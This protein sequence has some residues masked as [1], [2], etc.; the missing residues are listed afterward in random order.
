MSKNTLVGDSS[1][2]EGMVEKMIYLIRG[3]KVMLASDISALYGVKTKVLNLAVKRNGVR[4][5][6]DFMF[7]LTQKETD[8]LRFQFETSKKGRGG[9]RYLP[10]TFTQEGVA[11]LSGVLNSPRAV[12]ANILIMRTFAKL[13]ELIATNELIRQK[14]EELEKKYEKHDQQFKVVFDAIRQFLAT[15]EKP[16][17][18]IGFHTS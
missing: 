5:P 16:K 18:Q 7:Q 13:R 2:S 6:D 17:R 11:M 8:S 12:Q 10:Y 3:K 14:I 1:I 9:R 15:P 4:F